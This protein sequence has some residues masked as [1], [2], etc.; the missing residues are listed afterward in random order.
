MR[1]RFNYFSA[2]IDFLIIGAG[3]SGISFSWE[4][5]KKNISYKIIDPCLQNSSSY[6]SG[7]IINP[8]TGRKYQ[9]QWNIETLLSNAKETYSAISEFLGIELLQETS[10]IKFH[11]SIAA[12]EEYNLQKNS[13]NI[14]I[15]EYFD[16]NRYDNFFHCEYGAVIIQ[17]VLQLNTKRYIE[18]FTS[19]L[20]AQDKLRKNIFQSSDLK[21]TNSFF[22]YTKEQYKHIIFCD[23]VQCKQNAFFS[24][25]P[26]KPAKGECFII[27]CP[28]LPEDSVYQKGV[29]LI[30]LGNHLFWCGGTNSWND[31][32]TTPTLAGKKELEDHLQH[33]LKVD[34][35]I[36]EHKAAVRPTIKDRSPV[37][38]SHPSIKNMY[39]LNGMGTK[40]M[41]L[42][43]YYADILLQHI[44]TSATIPKEAN[45][46]RFAY[47]NNQREG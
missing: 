8:V 2:V 10:I 28:D 43:P 25:I 23:G 18:A 26:F 11:K 17:R 19:Y 32:T 30:P 12:L 34:Y 44:L 21:I 3:L 7:A 31:L 42:A 15:K 36:T 40:G 37:V 16:K 29:T 41:S 39:I 5:E 27:Q 9:Q 33:L 14:F 22:E 45:V 20:Y 1:Q 38:G 47:L 13:T 35:T 24:Y 4:L 6:I 46:S